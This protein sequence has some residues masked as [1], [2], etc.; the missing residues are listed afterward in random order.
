[1]YQYPNYLNNGYMTQM[2]Q[3][4]PQMQQSQNPYMDRITQMQAPQAQPQQGFPG[5]TTRM[6]EDFSYITAND[7]PMDGNG[8]F[9]VKKDGTEI[10]HRSWTGEGIIVT[11]PF[12]PVLNQHTVN[13]SPNN[14]E[15]SAQ[16]VNELVEVFENKFAQLN[17]RF[18]KLENAF[19][20]VSTKRKDVSNE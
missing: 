6:V 9:F 20:P 10:Q 2:Q 14:A 5:I 18:D 8:A 11:R 3:G 16:V 7:V 4:Y 17:E 19:K 15:T 12:K 1:M 13:D